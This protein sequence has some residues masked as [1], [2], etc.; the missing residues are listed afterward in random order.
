MKVLCPA[1]WAKLLKIVE[2]LEKRINFLE[3]VKLFNAPI[4]L[5]EDGFITL[6]I[7][8]VLISCPQDT[9]EY[10]EVSRNLIE[11]MMQ[12]SPTTKTED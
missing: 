7:G 12:T 2:L 4:A 3:K 5:R 11:T 8:R 6:Q 10:L 1:S 9:P